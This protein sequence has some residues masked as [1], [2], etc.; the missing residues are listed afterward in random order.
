MATNEERF[1]RID[2]NM[3]EVKQS[4]AEL[5]DSVRGLTQ[6]ILDFREEAIRRHQPCRVIQQAIT[7]PPTPFTSLTS[8]LL[9]RIVKVWN[10]NAVSDV[11][12][13]LLG[14]SN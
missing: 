8:L 11:A 4:I 6:Y 7:G 3:G 12:I 10:G 13:S 2:A 14:D 9:R 5:R 1:D